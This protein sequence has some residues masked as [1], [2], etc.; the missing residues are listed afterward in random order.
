MI[1]LGACANMRNTRVSVLVNSVVFPCIM[2]F[3]VSAS[4]EIDPKVK[5]FVG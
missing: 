1:S 5:I 3:R 4:N 2:S